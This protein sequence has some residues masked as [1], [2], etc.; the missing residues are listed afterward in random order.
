MNDES[1]PSPHN[2][3]FLQTFSKLELASA[4]LAD[5]LPPATLAKLDL[6][7]LRLTS[8]SFIDDELHETSS[9]LLFEV[10]R[11]DCDEK[12]L[13]YV[14][15]DH[16]SYQDRMTPFQLLKY[17]VR[18]WENRLRDG[19]PLCVIIPLVVYHGETRWTTS[20][21]LDDIIQAPMEFRRYVPQ[22]ALDML[23]LS[24]LSDEQLGKSEHLKPILLLLK[25]IRSP[26]LADRL[27]DLMRMIAD[28]TEQ[29]Y[30]VD[31]LKTVVIYLA[32]GTTQLNRGD[33][34]DAVH[35]TLKEQG[36]SLMPTIAQQWAEEGRQK[37][38]QEGRQEGKIE[39]QI[40]LLESLLGKPITPDQEL[41]NLP[42]VEL[43]ERLR[44]LQLEF[45]DRR[46]KGE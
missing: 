19:K 15:T 36:E 40:C 14:L 28:L 44:Q 20:L 1:L 22:F 21:T 39:G 13:V 31:F 37:G 2:R 32:T 27:V 12:V 17:M 30:G 23:D 33:L 34:V 7:S 4:L 18:I 26:T 29:G 45:S 5:H 35:I 25:Y 43:N 46:Q 38:R 11:V 16:K 42:L 9:D 10:D 6:K 3:F 8:G 24:D 41:A